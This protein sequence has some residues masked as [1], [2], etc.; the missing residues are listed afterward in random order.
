MENNKNISLLENFESYLI[1]EK[2]DYQWGSD[3]ELLIVVLSGKNGT[4]RLI[5]K[6]RNKD[7]FFI[8][9][10]TCPIIVPKNKISTI[11]EFINR[12][13]YNMLTGKFE[14]NYD[15]GEIFFTTTLNFEKIELYDTSIFEHLFR[16][17]FIMMDKYLPAV[18]EILYGNKTPKEAIADIENNKKN[19]EKAN[20]DI[21]LN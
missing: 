8:L 3:K 5:A 4:Y 2:L 1:S 11:S 13:N 19:K 15:D 12:A 9:Y 17:N 7:N 20:H 21:C 16:L 6:T 14:F 18:M 10:S